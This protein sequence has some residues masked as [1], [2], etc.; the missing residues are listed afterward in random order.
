LQAGDVDI[1]VTY[2]EMAEEQAVSAEYATRREY[3]FQ[4]SSRASLD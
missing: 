4:V 3:A 2:N 1:A